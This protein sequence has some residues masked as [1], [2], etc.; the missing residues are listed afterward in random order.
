MLMAESEEEVR[1]KLLK[2]KVGMEAKGQ[3][4]NVGKTKIMVRG[5][6]I[7]DVEESGK[8]NCGVWERCR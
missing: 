2:W 5:C 4:V 6:G 3:K 7:G 1:E 8:W